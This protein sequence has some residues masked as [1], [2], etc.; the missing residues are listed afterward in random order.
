MANNPRYCGNC[1]TRLLSAQGRYC[2]VCGSEANQTEGG[3]TPD[4]IRDVA[5]TSVEFS[6]YQS[7][8]TRSA[9]T[10][11]FLVGL[12]AATLAAFGSTIAEIGLLQRLAN[13]EFVSEQALMANDDRQ[14][15]IGVVVLLAYL[16]LIISFC[17]WIYRA[18]KN[19]QSLNVGGQRFS[20][21]WAVGWWFVP[22][23]NLVRPYQVVKELWKGSYPISESDD[24]SAWRNAPTSAILGWWWGIWIVSNLVNTGV[25]RA[26]LSDD[27]SVDGLITA[28]Y[29]SLVGDALTILAAVGI[30]MLIRRISSNQDRKHVMLRRVEDSLSA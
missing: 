11:I 1:G 2:P 19:L 15:L 23:M 18:A 25:S 16:V 17:I 9:W 21:G 8:A 4:G 27:I 22:F 7:P 30:F 20:P 3:L 26:S 29:F 5:P 24:S 6:P 13:G 10:S 14:G 28:D 12:I